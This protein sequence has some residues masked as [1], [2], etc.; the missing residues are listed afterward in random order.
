M[1]RKFVVIF[2]VFTF[3]FSSFA[4]SL[5]SLYA[6]LDKYYTS[7]PQR[8]LNI[9]EDI[10]SKIYRTNPQA[11]IELVARAI[12]LSDSVLHKEELSV[13]WK[14]R[15]AKEYLLIGKL[16]QAIRYY[17]QLRDYYKDKD[18]LAYARILIYLG[19]IYYKLNV[20]E[21][22]L[23]YYNQA[24]KIFSA[25][26][27]YDLEALARG[28]KAQVYYSNYQ[29]DTAY[30]ILNSVLRNN[31]ISD[32]SRADL[33]TILGNMYYND[34]ETD[35]ALFYYEKALKYY[36]NA[37]DSLTC[38]D[39]FLNLGNIY[40]DRG[41]DLHAVSFANRSYDIYRSYDA[42]A[43]LGQ[44]LNDLGKIYFDQKQFDKA[45]DYFNKAVIYGN[46]ARNSQVLETA[47]LYLS[48]IY[49]QKGD[50]AKAL[51]YH[52]SYSDELKKYFDNLVGQ[53][54]AEII[55]TFQNE[56]KQ[57]EIALLKKEETIRTQQLRF[58]LIALF[59]LFIVALVIVYMLRRLR[60]ANKLLNEQY[61]QI[62]LQK[63]ELETQSRIL[64]KATQDLLRQK[65]KIEKQNRDIEA[66]IRYASRIQR[67][68]L[69]GDRIFSKYFDE[70]FIF[71]RP[72]ETVSGDFYWVSEIIGDKPS[73]FRDETKRKVVIAVADCTGHGV[74]GAFMS[75]LGDAY[76]NQIIKVQRIS[77]PD[78]ILFELNKYIRETLQQSSTESMDGMDI[79]ICVIDF[80]ERTV[81]FAGAKQD[82]IYIQNEKMVRVH[83][84][85]HSI[86]GLKQEKNKIFTLKRVDITDTTIMYMYTDGFQDQ[87]GGEY[88]RKYMAKNF[89][90]FLYSIHQLP[91]QDQFVKLSDELNRW[92][93]N[94]YQQMD[95]ITVIG[96]KIRGKFE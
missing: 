11:T 69:P 87:F 28:K 79:G 26:H 61:K 18:K 22:A 62:K 86:G 9:I 19:D 52:K 21:I 91:M 63:R 54:Y 66:S 39:L 51:Y 88:G 50:L 38:A 94:K 2:F 77:S 27:Q 46:L 82:L 35:S 83:G 34:E 64:E 17:V 78:K 8:A 49:E 57:R 24:E 71:Y 47:Y 31:K 40:H 20:P 12:Y 37:G 10:Y 84:D 58:S 30:A 75:M 56:E 36:E 72:K 67:A 92:M 4:S 95:D 14:D 60:R 33:A 68:M 76:L 3:S 59:I 74:P 48:R 81:E 65:E 70:Y 55:L 43:Q 44:S 93:G 6:K 5:D 16:D 1:I 15:L 25:K 96:V 80:Q 85:M 7:D 89:R 13:L 45:I 42:K 53:G 23:D 32:K 41:D 73:L 90:S 29:V